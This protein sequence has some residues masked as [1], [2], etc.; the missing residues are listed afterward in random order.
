MSWRS[1]LIE[2][3][4]CLKLKLDNLV[5]DKN[6]KQYTLPL[7][8]LSVIVVDGQ[9][10][11]I[12]T[13]LLTHLSKYNITL[14]TCDESHHPCGMFN[15]ME[16]HV[17]ASKLIHR[18]IALKEEL[19]DLIWQQLITFKIRNQLAVLVEFERDDLAIE[20][21]NQYVQEVKPYD[22]TNREGH[23]AK[24]YFNA[25][26]GKDFTRQ[27]DNTINACLNYG[28]SIIRA[29]LSRLVVGYGLSPLLGVFHRS[30]YNAFN[31]VDDLIEPFR[32]FVDYM[33]YKYFKDE[34]YFKSEHRQAL[35]GLMTKR[36]QY[37]GG[38][39]TLQVVLEKYVMDFVAVLEHENL[40]RLQE[41]SLLGFEEL[42]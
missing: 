29:H 32:P 14:V 10:T 21:L 28:Y 37:K 3:G 9:R 18:Q 12:S 22:R 35:I 7:A 19:R 4:E 41:P 23:A 25:L 8:D 20:R 13:R 33:V 11:S 24:V 5:V 15:T 27:Q 16:G 39:Y 34:R 31:L 40:E 17:R 26:F 30:E 1:V 2:D 36:C 6:N 42:V 38:N